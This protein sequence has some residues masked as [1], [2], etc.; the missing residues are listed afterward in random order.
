[1]FEIWFT[2]NNIKDHKTARPIGTHRT[3]DGQ[4]RK[5]HNLETAKREAKIAQD[6]PAFKSSATVL[7]YDVAKDRFIN[8]K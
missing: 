2:E 4:P 7:I 8:V 3:E 1:M 5:F 6:H